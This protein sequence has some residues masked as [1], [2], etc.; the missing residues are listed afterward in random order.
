MLILL[1][2]YIVVIWRAQIPAGSPIKG[3]RVHLR[4]SWVLEGE[5]SAP[6]SH[7]QLTFSK[8]LL[9]LIMSLVKEYPRINHCLAVAIIRTLLQKSAIALCWRE[10]RVL[11]DMEEMQLPAI[12][13]KLRWE[14][15]LHVG[16]YKGG[17]LL[18][19]PYQILRL[20]RSN[21]PKNIYLLHKSRFLSGFFWSSMLFCR[22]PAV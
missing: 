5:H 22:A 9:N 8:R 21:N 19:P 11:R 4:L 17:G 12:N 18:F 1:N 2:I 7:A 3:L 6:F 15:T 20:L 16:V 13:L 14:Y 10:F